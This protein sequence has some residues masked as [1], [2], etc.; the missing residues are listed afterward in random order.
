MNI[1]PVPLVLRS[2]QILGGNV[3]VP[4]NSLS[5]I[6]NNFYIF[7]SY[8]EIV[9]FSC[10]RDFCLLVVQRFILYIWAAIRSLEFFCPVPTIVQRG[11]RGWKW[12]S[13]LVMT[14]GSSFPK[15]PRRRGF[16]ELPSWWARGGGGRGTCPACSP[17]HCPLPKHLFHLD[18]HRYPSSHPLRTNWYTQGTV[19]LNSVSCFTKLI[20]PEEGLWA[21]PFITSW[22]Q[23]Q[24]TTWPWG[25]HLK[26]GGVMCGSEPL[27]CGIRCYLGR[28]SEA[29]EHCMSPSWCLTIACWGINPNTFDGQKSQK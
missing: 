8:V 13:G 12:R 27:T 11:E 16:R 19:S 29:S 1:P 10:S 25:W 24:L 6:L 3:W 28:V 23:G 21:P 7:V 22:W 5:K 17:P 20:K 9:H 14:T 18:V 15:N 4:P 2:P 26:W